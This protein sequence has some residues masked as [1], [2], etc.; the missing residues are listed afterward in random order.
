MRVID[1]S[2]TL[3][4]ATGVTAAAL[5]LV[6]AAACESGGGTEPSGTARRIVV[7][8]MGE[9][10]PE[11]T[12]FLDGVK[13]EFRRMHPQT[14]VRVEY[15]PWPQATQKFQTA[16]AGGSG[17]DVTEVGNTDVRSWIQQGAFADIGAKVSH[18]AEGHDLSQGALANDQV[19]GRTYAVPW[20]GGVRAVW[21]RKDWFRDLHLQPPA[22]WA[23]LV[24]VARRIQKAKGVPGIAAPSDFTNGILSFVWANGGDVAAKQNGRWTGT[25][26]GPQAREAIEFYAGLVSKE[27]VAP[28]AYIGKNEL[29]GPQQ[30]FALGKVGMYMDGSWALPQLEKINKKGAPNWGVF[31]IPGRDGGLAPVFSGGSDLAVWNDSRHKD[32][33]FD[34]L[35]VLDGKRNAQAFATTL[36]FL[37]QF[38]DVL[39]SGT[40]QNDPIMGPFARAAEAGVRFTPASKGWADYEGAKKVL[41]NAVKAIM[42]GAS[43]DQELKKADEQAGS[44]LNE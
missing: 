19:D 42:Q 1:A 38:S 21:Y 12:R 3:R 24:A 31:P 25:L 41:P 27:K 36:K 14:D 4:F 18:W 20:Y 35:T 22:S 30:D 43:A 32:L 10:S 39:R 2:S 13:A 16:I 7:W 17:P 9:G 33:A 23:Q 29:Q 5:A 40:Y 44:L 15:V 34:Y 28:D 37:P 11:Q 8:Q 26:A 6:L